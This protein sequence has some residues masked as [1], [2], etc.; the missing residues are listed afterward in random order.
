MLWFTKGQKIFTRLIII[1]TLIIIIVP[2]LWVFF[3]AF[4]YP[5]EV[6][7]STLFIFPVNFHFTFQ[8]FSRTVVFIQKVLNI[9]YLRMY[10]NLSRRR[11][12]F[13]YIPVLQNVLLAHLH[14]CSCVHTAY[15]AMR[16]ISVYLCSQVKCS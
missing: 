12:D 1:V 9:S 10:L 11:D 7:E 8:N 14:F 16:Q 5:K 2:L 4:K 3:L 15:E 6:Y 13:K